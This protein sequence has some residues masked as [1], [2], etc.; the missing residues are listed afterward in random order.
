MPKCIPCLGK[1]IKDAIREAI[2]DKAT[3][4]LL[5]KVKDC[6]DDEA[7]EFCGKVG[8]RK[9]SAYQDFIGI[10]LKGGQKNIS[11]CAGEWRERKTN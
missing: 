6:P 1:D 8:K 9:T 2:E 4:A 10:C 11:Q 3:L 5:D 7:M